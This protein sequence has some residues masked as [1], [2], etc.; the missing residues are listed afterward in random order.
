MRDLTLFSG[1]AGAIW[2][3]WAGPRAHNDF[4]IDLKIDAFHQRLASR[5]LPRL[6][7]VC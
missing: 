4:L 2:R 1:T 3:A 7:I 5:P 6:R